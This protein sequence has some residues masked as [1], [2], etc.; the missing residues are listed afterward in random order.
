MNLSFFSG[1][2]I[3]NIVVG[4]DNIMPNPEIKRLYLLRIKDN[5]LD[6]SIDFYLPQASE[7]NYNAQDVCLFYYEK[8][9]LFFIID[10]EVINANESTFS[11]VPIAKRELQKISGVFSRYEYTINVKDEHHITVARTIHE[12]Y[13]NQHIDYNKETHYLFNMFKTKH[14]STPQFQTIYNLAYIYPDFVINDGKLYL[15][16]KTAQRTTFF[17]NDISEPLSFNDVSL[18]LNDKNNAEEV[19]LK[20]AQL[21]NL[22]LF[23]EHSESKPETLFDQN[24]KINEKIETLLPQKIIKPFI[25]KHLS[26]FIIKDATIHK[27]NYFD[28]TGGFLFSVAGSSFLYTTV[29]RNRNF[30]KFLSELDINKPELN[31]HIREINTNKRAL[32]IFDTDITEE[33]SCETPLFAITSKKIVV[34]KNKATSR[35]ALSLKHHSALKA[36]Q[37]EYIKHLANEK[38]KQE[39]TLYYTKKIVCDHIKEDLKGKHSAKKE[40]AALEYFIS[41]KRNRS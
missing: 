21:K 19:N 36:I 6:K 32:L 3:S 4:N 39:D 17:D 10:M 12:D 22:G 24:K 35:L 38:N 7:C 30:R 20:L 23:K 34:L 33:A 5:N 1:T 40:Q 29:C 28:N 2:V 9:G 26:S 8:D 16:R 41:A 18:I 11:T 14:T 13:D 31:T 15:S 37:A 27:I 25:T